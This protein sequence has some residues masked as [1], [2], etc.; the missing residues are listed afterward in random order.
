MDIQGKAMILL[1]SGMSGEHAVGFGRISDT[2]DASFPGQGNQ[3]HRTGVGE[4]LWHKGR[5]LLLYY[6]PPIAFLF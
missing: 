2:E 6:L 3:N 1:G 4:T 5:R